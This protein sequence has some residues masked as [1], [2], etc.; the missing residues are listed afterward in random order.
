M[1]ISKILILS[2]I[3]IALTLGAAAAAD[4]NSTA[5][6]ALEPTDDYEY[7]VHIPETVSKQ[8]P[9][10]IKVSGMPEDASGN[11]SI[12]VDEKEEYNQK[13]SLG[14]NAL[15]VNGL[16]LDD[17]IHTAQVKYS[18]DARYKG[19]MMNGTF[20]K[21]F[22]RIDFGDENRVTSDD[23][24]IFFIDFDDDVTGNVK[25]QIDGK[26]VLTQNCS[27][28]YSMDVYYK[29]L[30]YGIHTYKVT[31]T[32]GNHKNLVKTGTFN[33]TFYFD[34]ITDEEN[35]TIGDK[36]EFRVQFMDEET[37]RYNVYMNGKKYSYNES[38]ITLSDFD[39]GKNIINFTK[40]HR[41]LTKS[42][43]ITV[44]VAP[45]LK[46]PQTVYW[47]KS[48][49]IVLKGSKSTTGD[50]TVKVDGKNYTG[51]F[52]NG[53]AVIELDNMT[54]GKHSLALT[55]G[56]INTTSNITVIP[57]INDRVYLK[58]LSNFTFRGPETLN[59]N[60]ELSGLI[61][62]NYAVENGTVTV[63][64]SGMKSGLYTLN[65]TYENTTWNY[66]IRIYE[67]SPEW[68][69]EAQYSERVHKYQWMEEW[70]TQ[71]YPFYITNMPGGLTGEIMVYHDG[72]E[73]SRYYD[74]ME[75][76]P[77][78][79]TGK[80]TI[81]LVYPGDDYFHAV[82]KTFT[83]T[84]SDIVDYRTENKELYIIIPYDASGKVTV[85]IDGKKVETL[86]L[87]VDRDYD[88]GLRTWYVLLDSYKYGKEYKLE[89]TYSGNYGKC[90][91]KD[92][93]KLDMNFYFEE[94]SEF[95][96]GG[97]YNYIEFRAP[98]D[99]S[100]KM[101]VTIDGVKYPYE[102]YWGRFPVD[103]G[104]VKPGVHEIVVKYPGDSKYPSKT[105]KKTFW[106]IAEIDS[107]Y[108]VYKYNSKPKVSLLLPDD[109]TG[110]LTVEINGKVYA[111]SPVKNGRAT[112]RIPTDRLGFY[113]YTAYFSGNYDVKPVN[114]TYLVEPAWKIQ[115][116][117]EPNKNAT[118][119]VSLDNESKGVVVIYLE[120]IPIAEFE[121]D[122]TNGTIELD[123]IICD[124]A[125][126]IVEAIGSSEEHRGCVVLPF[127]AE[128]FI[129]NKPF[130]SYTDYV[131]YSARF[132]AE[133]IEMTY[134]DGTVYRIK[135]Y[136]I[137]GNLMAKGE[138]I[139]LEIGSKKY[140]LKTNKKG[141]ASVK[142]NVAP[143]KYRA[144][145]SY[146]AAEVSKKIT[147]KHLLSFKKVNVKKSARKLVLTA[148][149]SKKLKG[150]KITFKFNGKKYTAKTNK[151]G[152]AKV[153]VKKS[154][155]NK[156]KVGKKIKVQAAYLKDTVKYSVKVR[157]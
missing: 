134:G 88:Y 19:F 61:N 133:N 97:R 51:E 131:T 45:D 82:N 20:E 144:Y 145:I 5:D 8:Y 121:V 60:I 9:G 39:I 129:D 1:K 6:E 125:R 86:N 66:L 73:Y 44:N 103:I 123:S 116:K 30:S 53:K 48:A 70:E 138:K 147:V 124:K 33:H 52:I 155:L 101:T 36:L 95:T 122:S 142:I 10:T 77:N 78:F 64:V 16:N 71:Y 139:T 141:E 120:Y 135:A 68:D 38:I 132:E 22:L 58:T 13:V 37:F 84:V 25:A 3:L 102:N 28:G 83:Y 14:G 81:K 34:A 69:I 27:D 126:S 85:K 128:L 72:E 54:L 119:K 157:K 2:F 18:G 156:L 35:I 56:I 74:S 153:T 40:T 75:I 111:S 151:K 130:S 24:A 150:K 110:N 79:K 31:Y 108:G 41:S 50:V 109:A 43:A 29:K 96:Y 148:K 46:I 146:G 113:N 107:P 94:D 87:K 154:V 115:G 114:Y 152:V 12:S 105:I 11:I 59:G 7:Q 99:I 15:V 42:V 100:K 57:Y 112:V 143:K 91:V 65:I 17:G 62:G 127:E 80:H 90:T 32:G 67:E 136:D 92:T 63:P 76:T 98:L 55:S 4:D 104:D 149:L 21:S 23:S 117:L 140:T 47:G 137:F 106:V 26:T 89:I 93:F 49:E 118:L